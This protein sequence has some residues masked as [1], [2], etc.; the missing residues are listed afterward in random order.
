MAQRI[1]FGGSEEE[2]RKVLAAQH[3][4]PVG[5]YPRTFANRWHVK[6][7]RCGAHVRIAVAQL[8]GRP[9]R[10]RCRHPAAN[11]I[12]LP[13]KEQRRLLAAIDSKKA[14]ETR[15]GD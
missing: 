6:C 11:L 2:G 4:E 13:F 5:P 3:Y 1:Q 7:L 15:R 9:M 8:K 12:Q 14:E 10:T